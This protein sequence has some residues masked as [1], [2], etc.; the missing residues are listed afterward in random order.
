[1]CSQFVFL[2]LDFYNTHMIVTDDEQVTR[3]E[4][5]MSSSHCRWLGKSWEKLWKLFVWEQ[6]V[7]QVIWKYVG[8][9]KPAVERALRQV[10]SS[11]RRR[12]LYSCEAL[13]EHLCNALLSQVGEGIVLLPCQSYKMVQSA[14]PRLS[15]SNVP[16]RV[17]L[18]QRLAI[19]ALASQALR[20]L[21]PVS[22]VA[23]A[24]GAVVHLYF[25]PGWDDR[26][27]S[28][29]IWTCHMGKKTGEQ[30][31][32]RQ[33]MDVA[34]SWELLFLEEWWRDAESCRELQQTY[35]SFHG[36]APMGLFLQH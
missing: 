21:P 25:N 2:S 36:H 6:Q 28:E 22:V 13:W 14:G 16:G 5:N 29:A 24:D 34:L 26:R 10:P 30:E 27:S 4:I 1:M 19:E 8:Q 17:S 31:W 23:T 20:R 3:T 15:F 32:E 11:S 18:W 12:N 9:L 33:A 7:K 35:R